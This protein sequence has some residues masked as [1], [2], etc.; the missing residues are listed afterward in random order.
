[1]KKKL[2]R[3]QLEII[4]STHFPIRIIAGAGSGKTL[5][6]I[7]KMKSLLQQKVIK[8]LLAI[9]FTRKACEE[10]KRRFFDQV[11]EKNH[12]DIHILTYHGFCN[13]VLRHEIDVLG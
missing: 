2:T 10:I 11:E 1:L 3:E 4:E 7:E 12:S 5:V 6:L 9:T 8:S 13:M